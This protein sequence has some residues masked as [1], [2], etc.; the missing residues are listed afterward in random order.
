MLK[1]KL[2][3]ITVQGQGQGKDFI[4]YVHVM[5][6]AKIV[7]TASLCYKDKEVFKKELKAKTLKI[8]TEYDEK[9]AKRVEIE[10]IL[11][12]M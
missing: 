1:Y 7:E 10:K 2:D 8:K 5:D 6:G 3:T 4:A 9:E 11:G 12:E